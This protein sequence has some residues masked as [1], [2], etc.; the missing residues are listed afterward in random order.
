MT[1]RAAELLSAELNSPE[2]DLWMRA[3][4]PVISMDFAT[5]HG[6]LSDGQFLVDEAFHIT[7]VVDWD[8]MHRG[9]PLI[10][11]DLGVGAGRV[12]YDRYRYNELRRRSR[13]A[14][15]RERGLLQPTWPQI[16]LLWC[17]LDAL[18][19]L[20]DGG[21]ELWSAVITALNSATERVRQ[22]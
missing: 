14:Y 5:L 12:Y 13:R 17:L 9:H 8:G 21:G 20:H 19:L 16:N 6:E 1:Q 18:A 3:L 15:A 10:D 2:P 7:G 4:A 22:I 11:L